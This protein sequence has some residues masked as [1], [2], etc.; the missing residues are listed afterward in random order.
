MQTTCLDNNFVWH[1]NGM[2]AVSENVSRQRCI[3]Q[4][5]WMAGWL[6]GPLNTPEKET[7]VYIYIHY[8]ILSS[9]MYIFFKT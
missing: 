2:V 7:Y 1:E 3:L 6:D 9:F 5:S 8:M 4:C